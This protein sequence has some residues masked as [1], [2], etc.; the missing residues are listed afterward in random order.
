MQLQK[1]KVNPKTNNY[2]LFGSGALIGLGIL[3]IAYKMQKKQTRNKH[4]KKYASPDVLGSEQK[5]SKRFLAMIAKAEK[6][7]GFAFIPNSGYRTFAH[8]KKVGGVPNS[9]HTKGLGADFKA[10]SL[11]IRDRM[12]WALK[13]AGFK[14]IGIARKFVH[15]DIDSTKPQY[16]AWGYPIGSTPP[17]NPFA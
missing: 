5:M 12:V 17:Y 15:A 11:K 4:L 6:Y 3:F 14:R 10:H 2:L 1:G 7:A 13:K 9:S 16:V 8:N